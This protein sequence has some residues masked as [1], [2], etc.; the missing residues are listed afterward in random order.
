MKVSVEARHI[1]ACKPP[2][3]EIE[4]IFQCFKCPVALALLEATGERF[5]VGGI[6]D[7]ADLIFFRDENGPF[8]KPDL[9]AVQDFA[10]R[11][12]DGETVYPFTFEFDFQDARN[13]L[14]GAI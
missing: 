5:G 11:F 2:R 4:R 10:R 1:E 8:F 9:P 3:S 6:S 14:G 13:A 7:F 12:D